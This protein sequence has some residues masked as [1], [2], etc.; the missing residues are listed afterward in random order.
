MNTKRI[1]R[2]IETAAE[3]LREGSL[4]AIAPRVN[5]LIRPASANVEQALILF[6]LKSPDPNLVLLDRFLISMDMKGIP[7]A[8]CF[9]KQDLA[10]CKDKEELRET[11]SVA[12][13]S[14]VLALSGLHIGLI[15]GFLLLCFR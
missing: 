4:V 10:S 15:Y 1:S 9:N 2:E 3:L 14:H 8:I 7:S 13:V 5:E 11:Y 6:A 12:G